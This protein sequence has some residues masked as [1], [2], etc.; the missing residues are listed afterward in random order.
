[1]T[2]FDSPTREYTLVGIMAGIFLAVDLAIAS[3]QGHA[4]R[5][6]EMT[7]AGVEGFAIGTLIAQVVILALWAGLTTGAPITRTCYALLMLVGGAILIHGFAIKFTPE[8]LRLRTSWAAD[9]F[10]W[11]FLVV[12]FSAVQLSVSVIRRW[13]GYSPVLN[14]S[15][16]RRKGTIRQFTLAELLVMPVLLCAP[17]TA[18]TAILEMM[19]AAFLFTVLAGLMLMCLV[20]AGFHIWGLLR[21]DPSALHLAVLIGLGPLFLIPASLLFTGRFLAG[22]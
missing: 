8:I 19:G 17:L 11:L 21:P 9:Y 18:M 10:G 3:L 22:H 1:M 15:Q 4:F 6:G 2:K 13:M 7:V 16:A 5:W 20:Y 12:V 14:E